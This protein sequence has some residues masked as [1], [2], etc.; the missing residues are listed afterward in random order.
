MRT[1]ALR[2]PRIGEAVQ[3][4]TRVAE[5]QLLGND[6]G[7]YAAIVTKR[8]EGTLVAIAVLAPF[9][10]KV[11]AAG[12]VRHLTEAAGAERWWQF[13]EEGAAASGPAIADEESGARFADLE[14]LEDLAPA[15][16]ARKRASGRRRPPQR[17][18]QQHLPF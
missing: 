6:G 10:A 12:W 13:P 11:H 7:P 17:A 3:F 15:P 16:K 4:F 9:S 1:P 8:R 14:E 5:E 2:T 18:F